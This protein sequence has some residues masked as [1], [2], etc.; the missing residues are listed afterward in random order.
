MQDLEELINE[1][2]MPNFVGCQHDSQCYGEDKCCESLKCGYKL[3][4]APK[5]EMVSNKN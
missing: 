3:C 1:A 2:C 4:K 5:K